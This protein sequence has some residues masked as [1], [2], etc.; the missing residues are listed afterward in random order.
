MMTVGQEPVQG[1]LGA[2]VGIIGE[3]GQGVDQGAGQGGRVPHLEP[4]LLR[5]A[6]G[7]DAEDDLGLL[8]I[9]PDRAGEGLHLEHA[10]HIG[11]EG[12][13]GRVRFFVGQRLHPDDGLAFVGDLHPPVDPVLRAGGDLDGLGRLVQ[14][15]EHAAFELEHDLNRLLR[16]ELV[17]DV[18]REHDLVLLDEE[19][20][21]LEPDEQVLGGDDL[22]LALADPGS[23]AHGPGLDLPGGQAL[24]QGELDLGG[25][26][27]GRR[28]GGGP[29]GGVGE[30]G[31]DDG[32]NRRMLP[33]SPSNASA[34][35][36]SPP[37]RLDG[38]GTPPRPWPLPGAGAMGAAATGA[39]IMAPPIPPMPRHAAHAG[40]HCPEPLESR[41]RPIRPRRRRPAPAWRSRSASTR[42]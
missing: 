14:R 12:H 6:L 37:L 19:P 36:T 16:L 27:G 4:R 8:L 20:R 23:R 42:L 15:L 11:R 9:G 10:V 31:A 26:V 2:A 28:Q 13:L 22:G 18:G 7:R 30:V 32:L 17:V 39:A 34:E 3:V 33:G 21:R 5:L 29:E 35:T 41:R 40:R 1:L 38:A 25:A 24:G